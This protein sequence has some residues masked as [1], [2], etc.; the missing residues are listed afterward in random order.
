MKVVC[1]IKYH[2]TCTNKTCTSS[3][4]LEK[5]KKPFAENHIEQKRTCCESLN[6]INQH[7]YSAHCSFSFNG[8]YLHFLTYISPAQNKHA[9]HHTY[10]TTVL[11]SLWMWRRK[12]FWCASEPWVLQNNLLTEVEL[13]SK[14][15][16]QY[17]WGRMFYALRYG[18]RA[19]A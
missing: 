3:N 15:D 17:W 16:F 2:V 5:T 1:G 10:K 7:Y 6:A 8:F 19:I 14:V 12:S 18:K 4:L 13:C 11:E 9:S